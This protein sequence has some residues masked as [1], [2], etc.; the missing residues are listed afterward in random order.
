MNLIILAPSLNNAFLKLE[1]NTTVSSAQYSI[2]IGQEGLDT[3]TQARHRTYDPN[4]VPTN[5]QDPRDPS[6]N[7]G[8]LYPA[9][10]TYSPPEGFLDLVTYL[11]SNG[12]PQANAGQ[13]AMLAGFYNLTKQETLQIAGGATLESILAANPR[14]IPKYL[15]VVTKIALF[16]ADYTYA[17]L[18][19]V[20]PS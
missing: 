5:Y 12:V 11:M 15:E 7:A 14:V 13:L 8:F 10:A 3:G 18:E 20:D 16:P 2:H 19:L 1:D 4:L 9:I 17:Y 6:G